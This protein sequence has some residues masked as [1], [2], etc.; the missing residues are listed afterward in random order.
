M[1]DAPHAWRFVAGPGIEGTLAEIA[2][3]L[4]LRH[5]SPYDVDVLA[6]VR[7]VLARFH[8]LAATSVEEAAEVLPQAATVIAWKTRLLLPA[9]PRPA[10]DL[11]AIER[12]RAQALAAIAELAALEGAIADLRARRERRALLLPARATPPDYPRRARPLRIAAATLA[13]LA[14]KF[15]P[16]GYFEIRPE[17]TTI[18]GAIAHLLRFLGRRRPFA[19]VI[20]D[21]S[22]SV[23]AVHFVAALELVRQG[24]CRLIQQEAFGPLD[25][26]GAEPPPG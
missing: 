23:R 13:D 1:N 3:A 18:Q 5:H 14:G 2:R 15:A 9:A 25:V 17:G 19:E 7:A 21:G 26:E 24:R 6:L 10:D 8:D 22:W 11:E 4:R 12:D 20:P 16:R